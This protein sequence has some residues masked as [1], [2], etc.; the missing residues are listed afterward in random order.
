MAFEA[1]VAPLSLTVRPGR[2]VADSGAADAGQLP[3]IANDLNDSERTQ[4][5]K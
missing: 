5:V 1:A 4:A 3:A 2:P